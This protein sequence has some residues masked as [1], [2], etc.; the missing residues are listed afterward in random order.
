ML[1]GA[2]FMKRELITSVASATS[3]HFNLISFSSLIVPAGL[4]G[5]LFIRHLKLTALEIAITNM[6]PAPG[7]RL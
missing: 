7:T 3:S 5:D 4:V 1:E 6:D 2:K